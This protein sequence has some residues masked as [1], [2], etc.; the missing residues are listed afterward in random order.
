MIAIVA[1]ALPSPSL[2]GGDVNIYSYRQPELIQPLLDAFTAR[3]GVA[4]NVVFLNK[5]LVER[6]ASEGR[7]SPVDVILT[8]DIGRLDQARAAGVTQ[9]VTSDVIAGNIP[10]QY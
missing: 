3:T 5:G 8:V 7:N 2:A 9:A 6:V 4:T 10:A 1:L